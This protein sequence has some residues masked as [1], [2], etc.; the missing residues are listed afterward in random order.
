MPRIRPSVPAHD[1]VQGRQVCQSTSI[2]TLGPDADLIDQ[3]PQ[4]FPRALLKTLKSRGGLLTAEDG[5]LL[6][7]GIFFQCLDFGFG[8]L[9][10]V[11]KFP[12]L[13]QNLS[14]D[15]CIVL[16]DRGALGKDFRGEFRTSDQP[17]KIA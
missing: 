10:F 14:Y 4:L 7:V 3:G 16:V 5:F 11:P 1:R 13:T 6:S 9:Q 12:S 15:G 2:L 17:S 8:L